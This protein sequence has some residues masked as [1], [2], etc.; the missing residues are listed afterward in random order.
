MHTIKMASYMSM[1]KKYVKKDDIIIK[2]MH[3][4]ENYLAAFLAVY[5]E[6]SIESMKKK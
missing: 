5:D 2:G 6:V 3:N 1:V 4:V